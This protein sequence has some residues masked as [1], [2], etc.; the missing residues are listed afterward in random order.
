MKDYS[1]FVH[2]V[3][4]KD[5]GSYRDFSF[6]CSIGQHLYLIKYGQLFLKMRKS[7]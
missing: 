4:L 7:E 3:V 5:P 2:T 6:N 1:V